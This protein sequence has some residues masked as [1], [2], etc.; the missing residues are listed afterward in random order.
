[1]KYNLNFRTQHNQFYLYDK[2]SP[3]NTAS[4]DFWTAEAHDDRLALE[5][6]ILGIGTQCYGH[7][8]GELDVLDNAN[9]A[10]DYNHYD[11]VV[12][13]GLE[14]K[15]G[16]LQVLDCPNSEVELEVKLTPGTYRVRVYSSNLASA[17]I[18]EV[19][20]NDYY[21]IKIWPDTNME[22]KVLKR[23]N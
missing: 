10:V 7:I 8:K 2:A 6:G 16:V 3:A 19:E 9:Q 20:G 18:D 23:Y 17:D 11:H 4:D 13:G 15:S 21:K 12:E 1:M 22:R 14:V 5:N